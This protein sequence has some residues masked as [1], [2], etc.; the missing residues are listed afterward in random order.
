MYC[1]MVTKHLFVRI[2]SVLWGDSFLAKGRSLAILATSIIFIARTG[3][4]HQ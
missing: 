4:Q 2:V 3:I 1:R